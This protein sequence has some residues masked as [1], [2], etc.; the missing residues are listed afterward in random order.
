MNDKEFQRRLQAGQEAVDLAK[1]QLERVGQAARDDSLQRKLDEIHAG[2]LESQRQG[3]E[4]S[5]WMRDSIAEYQK[6]DLA[7]LDA[8]IERA[9]V[10]APRK[11]KT[12]VRRNV[13]SNSQL[14]AEDVD[15]I[16]SEL[17]V[18]KQSL[19]AGDEDYERLRG[20]SQL[21]HVQ[22]SG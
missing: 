22:S 12:P 4:R 9:R 1:A 14:C 21:S 19:E 3:G 16:Y 15:R 8:Q 7:L 20:T 13:K 11:S 2:Y 17:H 6:R 5:R 10:D 18:L